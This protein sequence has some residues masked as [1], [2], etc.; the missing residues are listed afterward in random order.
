MCATLHNLPAFTGAKQVYSFSLENSFHFQSEHM[1]DTL[2][3][4]CVQPYINNVTAFIEAHLEPNNC[5]HR[6]CSNA[7]I[8]VWPEFVFF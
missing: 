7:N 6:A 3:S 8:F 2:Q 1:C 4:T 5:I